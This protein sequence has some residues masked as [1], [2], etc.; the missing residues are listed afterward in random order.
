ML[1]RRTLRLL[2]P[3]RSHRDV[4][5]LSL[6]TAVCCFFVEVCRIAGMLDQ[7]AQRATAVCELVVHL[8]TEVLGT[9]ILCE[10][11]SRCCVEWNAT[12]HIRCGQQSRTRGI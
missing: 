7:R 3:L 8:T 1:V 9:E 6:C 4:R 11:T 2:S 12:S 10:F 5:P